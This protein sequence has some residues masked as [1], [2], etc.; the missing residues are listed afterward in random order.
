[1]LFIDL[2]LQKTARVQAYLGCQQAQAKCHVG[3]P[4]PT[5]RKWTREEEGPEEGPSRRVRVRHPRDVR[6][7]GG[8]DMGLLCYYCFKKV[9]IFYYR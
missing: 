7:E 6:G 3:S 9:I 4:R 5:L 8:A 1:M 2:P